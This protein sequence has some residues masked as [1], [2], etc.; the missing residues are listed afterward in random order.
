MTVDIPYREAWLQLDLQWNVQAIDTPYEELKQYQS[1]PLP[2]LLPELFR[3]DRKEQLLRACEQK[4]RIS[5]RIEASRLEQM[6]HAVF[7]PQDEQVDLILRWAPVQADLSW[8]QRMYFDGNVMELMLDHSRDAAFVISPIFEVMYY[9]AR[10]AGDIK[11]HFNCDL[12]LRDDFWQFVLPGTET[13]FLE[14]INRALQGE[15][16][17]WAE[18]PLLFPSQETRWYSSTFFPV[19]NYRNELFGVGLLYYDMH[20]LKSAQEEVQQ[21]QQKL[22]HISFNQSHRIRRH[23]ANLLALEEMLLEEL[24]AKEDLAPSLRNLLTLVQGETERL[25]QVIHEV[26]AEIYS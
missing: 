23:V 8:Q 6:A 2:R 21:H 11:R 16:V 20:E 3:S 7:L 25:D 12:S 19:R 10:A 26:T 4:E 22:S 18:R 14:R 9:N 24:T 5:F 13:L 1:R 15:V 17:H